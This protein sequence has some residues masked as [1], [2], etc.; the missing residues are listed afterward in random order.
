MV[1]LLYTVR[2]LGLVRR[3]HFFQT[4]PMTK[5]K[6]LSCVQVTDFSD[7]L[8]IINFHGLPS[9]ALVQM[10]MPHRSVTE[11]QADEN[12]QCLFIRK[13]SCQTNLFYFF[14]DPVINQYSVLEGSSRCHIFDS[15]KFLTLST[16]TFLQVKVD[17]S[18]LLNWC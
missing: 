17:R 14:Y 11:S 10:K 4:T 12:C 3:P 5:G 2:D 13:R 8:I 16:P 1:T 9:A 18:S 7:V 15:G 6:H